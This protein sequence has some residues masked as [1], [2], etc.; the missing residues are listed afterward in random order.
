MLPVKVT[1]STSRPDN[2][3]A[4]GE[5]LDLTVTV[6]NRGTITGDSFTISNIDPAGDLPGESHLVGHHHHR[7]MLL[8][9]LAHDREHLRGAVGRRAEDE[10]AAGVV[11]EAMVALV[12]ARAALEKFGGDSLA[13]TRTNVENYLRAVQEREPQMSG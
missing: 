9:E 10:P 1:T 6:T 5:A 7:H 4:P 12:V 8:G 2:T 13:E 3:G 11:V